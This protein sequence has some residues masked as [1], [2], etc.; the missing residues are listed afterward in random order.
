M[1]LNRIVDL[2]DWKQELAK[3]QDALAA[4]HAQ[5]LTEESIEEVDALEWQIIELEDRISSATPDRLYT[6][7]VTLIVAALLFVGLFVFVLFLFSV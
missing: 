5:P 6:V 4:L 1:N 3:K 2:A 7:G